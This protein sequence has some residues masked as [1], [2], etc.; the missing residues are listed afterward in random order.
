MASRVLGC[1]GVTAAIIYSASFLHKATCAHISPS[2]NRN[3]SKILL[4][5]DECVP[6]NESRACARHGLYPLLGVTSSF[7]KRKTEF[8]P[9][10]PR[11]HPRDKSGTILLPPRDSRSWERFRDC[12]RDRFRLQPFRAFGCGWMT[13]RNGFLELLIKVS[14]FGQWVFE[15]SS[16]LM[17][18]G[19]CNA[20]VVYHVIYF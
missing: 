9:C 13:M 6:T 20:N 16:E 1:V 8:D 4:I 18:T 15:L 19:L 12:P 2:K 11:P 17:F 10:E 7:S 3:L 5:T 14:I